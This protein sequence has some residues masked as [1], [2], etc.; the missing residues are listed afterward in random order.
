MTNAKEGR[1]KVFSR[2]LFKVGK[3]KNPLKSKERVVLTQTNYRS[4][5]HREGNLFLTKS[6][7]QGIL[8]RRHV[9][10]MEGSGLGLGRQILPKEKQTT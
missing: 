8:Q 3:G 7:K 10:M 5:R 1:G 6:R 4:N 2:R 9:L